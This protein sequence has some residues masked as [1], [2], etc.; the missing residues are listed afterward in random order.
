MQ[1]FQTIQALRAV[2][3]LVDLFFVISGFV[4]VAITKDKFQQVSQ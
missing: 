4:I 2:A 3:V 1:K